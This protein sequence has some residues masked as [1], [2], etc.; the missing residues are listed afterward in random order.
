MLRKFR[1]HWF[2]ILVLVLLLQPALPTKNTAQESDDAS[3]E[4]PPA[5][6]EKS[7]L[8]VL[9]QRA[10]VKVEDDAKA[11]EAETNEEVGKKNPAPVVRVMRPIRDSNI[12][13]EQSGTPTVNRQVDRRQLR[14][15]QDT[16]GENPPANGNVDVVTQITVIDQPTDSGDEQGQDAVTVETTVTNAPPSPT[17]R[18]TNNDK[19]KDDD[20]GS[21]KTVIIVVVVV[22]VVVVIAIVAGIF[23]FRKWK[24]RS[25]RQANMKEA[26]PANFFSRTQETDAMFLR[27]LND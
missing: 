3:L 16:G 18:P 1:V 12:V 17:A 8:P 27:Q 20:S 19:N 6:Q 9:K 14:A 7:N 10:P 21:N 5:A 25:Q 24:S 15:R 26:L 22:V 4:P 11:E 23:I 13:S 2:V